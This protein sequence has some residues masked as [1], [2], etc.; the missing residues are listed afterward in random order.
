MHNSLLLVILLLCP[1]FAHCLL[2]LVDVYLSPG[3][4]LRFL[5]DECGHHKGCTASAQVFFLWTGGP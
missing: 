1:L 3:W 2:A 5:E 4:L